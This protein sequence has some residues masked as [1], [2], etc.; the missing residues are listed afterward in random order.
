M[1]YTDEELLNSLKLFYK[2]FG[3][4][5]SQRDCVKT[6]LLKGKNTYCNRFG[7]W[8]KALEAADLLDKPAKTKSP[9]SNKITDSELIDYL[10]TFLSEQG[11]PPTAK[12]T[13]NYNMPSART[14][15]NRFGTW[16]KALEAA[17][18][19]PR[20]NKDW[21]TRGKNHSKLL[22][23]E[24]LQEQN[25]TKTIVQISKEL[26]YKSTSVNAAFKKLEIKPIN[27]T[28]S[29]KEKEWLDSLNLNLERQYKIENY[30]VDG[31]C[32]ET[33]TVYEFLGDY[34]HGNPDVFDPE[35]YNSSC[36]KT[37]GQLF[38][39]TNKRLEYIKS[40]GYNIITQ[41]ENEYENTI[42][43]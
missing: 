25:K 32:K 20:K 33:N 21:V 6:D 22:D 10:T 4:R 15:C 2:E 16:N 8:N 3:Y 28:E 43:S 1:K 37:F 9:P 27:H 40:L 18:I 12:D 17:N 36:N 35:D 19:Q 38:D 30:K 14:Y 26:G 7:T 5:P 24:W 42:L 23:K 41:W 34:W 39:E 11:R 29:L 13:E 31:Y